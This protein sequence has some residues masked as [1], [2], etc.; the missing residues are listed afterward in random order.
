M[1]KYECLT[2]MFQKVHTEI[3]IIGLSQIMIFSRNFFFNSPSTQGRKKIRTCKLFVFF[4]LLIFR[5]IVIRLFDYKYHKLILNLISGTFLL[6]SLTPNSFH[7]LLFAISNEVSSESRVKWPNV[8]VITSLPF[9]P[10][11]L[12]S[13]TFSKTIPLRISSTS[14][15]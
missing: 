10:H 6:D 2:K 8:K 9:P 4:L 14:P 3:F 13:Y 12:A 11:S 15:R 5:H 1:T 7:P